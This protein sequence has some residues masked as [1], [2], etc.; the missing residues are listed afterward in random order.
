MR[1][2]GYYA[3]HTFKN[4]L[5]KLFK[6]WVFVFVLVCFIVGIGM[7]L[8]TSILDDSEDPEESIEEPIEEGTGFLEAVGLTEGEFIE[9]IAGGVVL[10]MFTFSALNADKNGSRIFQPADVNLLFA[11]PMKPQSVLMFRLGTQ[12]GVGI[13]GSV[14]MLFQLP[15]L[16][17]NVGLDLWA[18]LALV[19]AWGLTVAFG[20]LLQLTLYMLSATY[21]AVK[22]N[23]R[24]CIYLMLVLIAVSFAVF[25]GRS[26]EGYLRS[27]VLFFNAKITR[28]IPLWGWIKGLCGFAA[29]GDL[30]GV[31]LTLAALI[32]GGAALIWA[33]WHIKADFYEDAMAK[34]EETAE[35]L[36]AVNS[37]KS[38][39]VTVR[40]KKDRS[41]K[42][43]RDGFNKGS[44]ANVYFYKTMYNRRRFAH[45]G[46][47]TKTMETY[48]VCA[49]GVSFICRFAAHISTVLPVALI[50][51][52]LSFFRAL[53]NQLEQDTAMDFFLLIPESTWAKLFWSLMGSTVCCLLDVLPAVLVGAVAVGANP[54]TALLWVPVIVSVD[55]YTTT[56]G[57]FIGLSTPASAGKIVKQL[58]QILFVYF[59]LVPD[60]VIAVAGIATGHTY[61]AMAAAALVNFALGLVFYGLAPNFIDPRGGR[62]V[63]NSY[64]GDWKMARKQFSRLGFGML[65]VLV[66]STVLQLAV[67]LLA[68]WIYRGAEEPGW[69]TWV[70]SFAPMYLVAIPL[71]ILIMRKAPARP[72]EK[73]NL[74]SWELIGTA[75]ISLFLMYAGNIVGNIIIGITSSIVGQTPANPLETYVENEYVWLRILVMV[76]LAP[77]IEEYLFRKQLI[78]RMNAYGGRVAVVTSALVFGL[79]H[80]NLSQFFYAFALGLVFGYLY[81]R[82][83]QLRYSAILHMLINFLGGYVAPK[84]LEKANLEVLENI[85]ARDSAALAQHYQQLMP[86]LIY[87]F[88]T[89][90]LSIVGFVLFCKRFRRTEFEPAP[91]E[92]QRGESF[93]AVYLNAGMILYIVA[94]LASVVSTFVV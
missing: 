7:G 12:L 30:A 31:L 78:D 36:A 13:L 8:L 94:C 91:Q 34:S 20:M 4:Q 58:V 50:L 6:T 39:G 45:L 88:V 23:L 59:G 21:P 27:S 64:G 82:T 84:L 61:T 52:A 41:E 69:L 77:L 9:L 1:L 46:V 47:F 55:F 54:L 32:L 93:K 11:S 16:V 24:R 56:V 73:R 70:Y 38:T 51:G 68:E 15:N 42:I 40:R 74:G 83:G 60:I 17:V 76:I 29:E 49:L 44:G 90:T 71:G 28:Y 57:T 35:L 92:L 48:L 19:A 79:A 72:L 2:F 5:R 3:L 10:L 53:G 14:Y 81:L 85:D 33:I 75:L 87:A 63:R 43:A 80:G 25:A 62:K 66:V 18:A 89:F 22:R 37:E 67:M 65:V 26:G 86:L